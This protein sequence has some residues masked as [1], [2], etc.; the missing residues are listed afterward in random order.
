MRYFISGHIDITYEEFLLR[1]SDQIDEALKDT[2]CSFLIGDSDGT[3]KFA[4]SYLYN[5]IDNSKI[6]IYHIGKYCKNNLHNYQ[7]SGNYKNHTQKDEAMTLNSDIDILWIRSEDQMK[8]M[9]GNKYRKRIS[10]TEKNLI[11]RQQINKN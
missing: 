3:D 1:Y 4:Q 2:N 8:Q 7:T 11:R 9:Y 5:K 10:G 6:T